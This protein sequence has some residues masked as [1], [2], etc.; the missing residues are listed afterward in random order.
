MRSG[1]R[2]RAGHSGSTAQGLVPPG[3]RVPGVYGRCRAP[4]GPLSGDVLSCFL[5][6]RKRLVVPYWLWR[7][8]LCAIGRLLNLCFR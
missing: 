1:A 8:L 7:P 3:G 2:I 6:D 4:R 5:S